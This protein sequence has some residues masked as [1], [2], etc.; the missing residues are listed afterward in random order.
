MVDSPAPVS[1][2]EYA[3]GDV[4]A[5]KYRLE[6]LLGEGGQAWVWQA[7]NIALDA[8]VAIKV[9]RAAGAGAIQTRR[10]LQEARSAAR[11]GHPAIVRVFDLGEDAHGNPF[12]VMEMLEGETLA[13]RLVQRGRLG[14]VEAVRVLLPIAD[15]LGVAHAKG[16]VHRDLKP[17]NVF[18]AVGHDTLQPKL[19]D[20]GIVK[21]QQ[22]LGW[23]ENATGRGVVVGSPAYLSPEQAR[24][25]DDVD[26]RADIWS[27]CVTL[28][29][30]LTGR[31]PFVGANYHALLRSIVEE[32][33]R[34][35]S[36]CGVDEDELWQIL[37]RGMAKARD[38]R[39][40]SA[41]ELG[42]ALAGWASERGVLDDVCRTPLEAKWLRADAG[43]PP[44]GSELDRS[45]EELAETA[46]SNRRLRL[47]LGSLTVLAASG[48]IGL[49]WPRPSAIPTLPPRPE[50]G[51]Q[52]A[53]SSHPAPSAVA[54]AS[55]APEPVVATTGSTS[56]A[57]RP[58]PIA[59]STRLANSVTGRAPLRASAT[60]PA[61]S[62]A[63][64]S[65]AVR[66][67]SSGQDLD[68]IKPY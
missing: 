34:S 37:I 64:R 60:L 28:Y 18:L 66:P 15:A 58:A 49:L 16:I 65:S 14:P 45:S 32:E 27:F 35:L 2:D 36:E 23:D 8:P 9:L 62:V 30:C 21:L 53:F 67:A 17:D 11:L 56:I 38:E 42:R 50:P 24:G 63:P 55:A 41:L 40:S 3:I 33:P 5:S 7:R 6:R 57:A 43:T 22:P 29:E 54:P 31:V 4:I 10:L 48:A 13:D 59:P 47:V 52:I 26:E 46:A 20:F 39:W 61:S 51:A 44:G 1:S 12:L 25:W 19:L 68:L